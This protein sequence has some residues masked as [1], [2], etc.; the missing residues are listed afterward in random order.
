MDAHRFTE[1][2]IAAG[3]DFVSGVPCS[4]LSPLFAACAASPAITYCPATQEGEAI[5]LAAGAWLAGRRPVVM[6]QNSG[7]GNAVNPI[8]SLTVPFG[9][10]L[11]LVIGWRGEPG[12]PDEPQHQLMGEITPGLLEQMTVERRPLPETPERL[13]EDLAVCANL[14]AADGRSRAYLIPGG[15][16]APVAECAAEPFCPADER[17]SRVSRIESPTPPPSRTEV[18]S[19]VLNNSDNRTFLIATTGKCGRELFSLEDRP[20]NFYQVG[21]M[22]GAS[23]IALGLALNCGHRVIVLDGDGAA[24]MRMGT[25]ATIGAAQPKRLIHIVLD[26]GTHDSTGGQPT[27]S[28]HVRFADVALACNYSWATECSSLAGVAEMLNEARIPPGPGL[29]HVRIRPGSLKKLG[30]P[31]LTPIAIAN[32][33]R[34]AVA[35]AN[36]VEPIA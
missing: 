4:Y 35:K 31:T 11:L 29:I 32:R 18:L 27:V 22:G 36:A 25:I 23:S 28:R 6:L 20:Q 15:W 10:P 9:I 1:R 8:T 3:F 2:L 30:R 12:R 17:G 34:A 26:N 7:L 19:V 13:A 16:F 5:C 14:F 33:F 21:S 24:L